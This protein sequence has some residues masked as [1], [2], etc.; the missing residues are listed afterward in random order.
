M[1]ITSQRKLEIIFQRTPYAD[2]FRYIQDFKPK[3][4]HFLDIFY[5]LDQILYSHTCISQFYHHNQ[6]QKSLKFFIQ[7]LYTPLILTLSHSRTI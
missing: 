5:N 3:Q 1:Q 6:H 2:N 4:V 7:T